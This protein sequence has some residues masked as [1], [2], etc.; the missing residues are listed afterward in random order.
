MLFS[1][2]MKFPTFAKDITMNQKQQ[3]IREIV[4]QE[5]SCAAHNLDHVMRVYRLSLLLAESESDVD[6]DILIPAVLLHD[7][8]R[9]R[10]DSDPTGTIDHA[11][12]GAEMATTILERLHYEA[13]TIAKITHCIAAHRFRTHNQP[14]SI[15][16]KILFDADKLDVIGAV[17]IARSF[18]LSG[19]YHE[20][21]YA[22]VSL[23]EYQAEN[24]GSNGRIKDM[25]KHTSNLEYELKLKYIPDRLYT[26]QARKIAKERV[27]F[28]GE[29]FQRLKAELN[30]E[31]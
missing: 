23:E 28:M 1:A 18:M 17:G 20:P 22:D 3:T 26:T 6:L 14:E 4:A 30:V 12:L 25:A 31:K 10:E 16:A 19:E 15:E 29:F 7:I 9:V 24:T 5:L 8:A 13:A 27:E 2:L 21:L 11:I